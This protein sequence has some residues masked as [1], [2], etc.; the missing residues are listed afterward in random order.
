[1]LLKATNPITSKGACRSISKEKKKEFIIDHYLNGIL[2]LSHEALGSSADSEYLHPFTTT[3]IFCFLFE[4]FTTTSISFFLLL[5]LFEVFTTTNKVLFIIYFL[6]FILEVSTTTNIYFMNFGGI[7]HP[8][9]L[10]TGQWEVVVEGRKKQPL[11]IMR[12]CGLYTRVDFVQCSYHELEPVVS[13][14]HMARLRRWDS[15]WGS[16]LP[17]K[18]I[19]SILGRFSPVQYFF[20]V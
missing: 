13:T 8:Q 18:L 10:V 11:I 17:T 16:G 7:L 15:Q 1:M 2:K 4:V 9:T 5:F 14:F 19:L 20:Y 6:F 12:L 3:N